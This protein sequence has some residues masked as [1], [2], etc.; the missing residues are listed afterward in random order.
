MTSSDIQISI[1]VDESAEFLEVYRTQAFN[2]WIG[3]INRR[4]C[5]SKWIHLKYIH[6]CVDA[7][8]NT[9]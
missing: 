3:Y 5:F 8:K 6:S 9:K 4:Q 1:I 7:I 2:L